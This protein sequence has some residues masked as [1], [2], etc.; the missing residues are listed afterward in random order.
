MAANE[1]GV[2]PTTLGK[3]FPSAIPFASSARVDSTLVSSVISSVAIDLQAA[4]Y[5]VVPN[6][7]DIRATSAPIAYAWLGKTLELGT[8]IRLMESTDVGDA[9]T[10]E[11]WRAEFTERMATLR[12]KPKTVLADLSSFQQ[13][14]RM[15]SL[16]R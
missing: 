12:N 5:P 13:S 14:S 7:G 2:T 8:V 6:D 11:A 10:L 3:W 1:Y 9:Q 4:L 16:W 15:V